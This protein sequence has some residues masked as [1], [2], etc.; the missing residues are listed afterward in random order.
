MSEEVAQPK[1]PDCKIQGVEYIVS[2]DSEEQHGSGAA[3][4]NIAHCSKCGHIY[5]VF[6]KH[7]TAPSPKLG[8]GV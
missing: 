3:W 1:C 6:T 4:F 2:T 7:T 5:G 8:F